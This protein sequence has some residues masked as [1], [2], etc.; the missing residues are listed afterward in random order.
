MRSAQVA[1][2][3]NMAED[4]GKKYV[5]WTITEP[6]LVEKHVEPVKHKTTQNEISNNII[7]H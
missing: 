2:V 7:K 6:L 5:Q 4:V 3:I 1:V